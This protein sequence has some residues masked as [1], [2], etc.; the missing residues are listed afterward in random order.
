MRIKTLDWIALTLTVA[1]AI[2]WGMI[3]IFQFNLIAAL[4]DDMNSWLSRG[5]YT[6]TGLAGLYC[7]RLYGRRDGGE[8]D[9]TGTP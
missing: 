9:I 7:L 5:I 3:G 6:V 4:F 2:N 1:G 8:T